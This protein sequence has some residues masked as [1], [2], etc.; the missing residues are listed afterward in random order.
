MSQRGSTRTLVSGKPQKSTS[1]EVFTPIQCS[2]ASYT[3]SDYTTFKRLQ[4]LIPRPMLNDEGAS[5]C[6]IRARSNVKTGGKLRSLD[7]SYGHTFLNMTTLS[8]LL[9]VANMISCLSA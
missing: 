6:T 1:E 2:R 8:L 9:E 7:H 5:V 4:L 3:F